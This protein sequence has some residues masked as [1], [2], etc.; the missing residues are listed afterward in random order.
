MSYIIEQISK[1]RNCDTF[2]IDLENTDR[3]RIVLNENDGTKTAYYFSSPIYN[4][5][6]NKLVD[7]TFVINNGNIH[8]TGS[9]CKIK[10]GETLEMS[11]TQG[12]L[13]M[14]FN[15]LPHLTSKT[16]ISYDTCIINPTLN[17][18]VCKFPIENTD[19]ISFVI[20]SQ[21]PYYDIRTND[22]CFCFMQEAFRPFATVSCIGVADENDNIIAPSKMEYIRLSG[23]KYQISVTPCCQ[24]G[25]WLTVEINLYEQKLFQD[26]TVESGNPKTNNAFGS[27][28]FIGNTSQYGKQWLYSR[29][30]F[31]KFSQL[32]DKK[33]LK[34]VLHMPKYNNTEL[35]LRAYKVFAR[36]CSFGS[37]WENR[38]GADGPVAD[39]VTHNGYESIDITTLLTDKNGNLI[40]TE[41]VIIKPKENKTSFSE[42]AT[43]DS[44]YKPQI[45]KINFKNF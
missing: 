8:Y 17:G 41:G 15:A 10:F 1:L 4:E 3:Y 21:N 36:F 32:A 16:E 37:N 6:T 39:S 44:H 24:I 43:A 25:K 28:A 5:E 22:R 12:E 38:M 42:I 30:D 27:V 2:D 35:T 31:F 45:L 11:N 9:N 29:P 18:I 13:T 40:N 14:H 23:N 19:S 34:A 26:T 7:D 20:E 33:I